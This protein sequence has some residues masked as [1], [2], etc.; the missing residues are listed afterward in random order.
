F[1]SPKSQLRVSILPI[2]RP[3]PSSGPR[4]QASAAKLS[5]GNFQIQL[6]LDASCHAVISAR[7]SQPQ[8]LPTPP[9]C[10]FDHIVGIVTR[11]EIALRSRKMRK[12]AR[13]SITLI[14]FRSLAHVGGRQR[15]AFYSRESLTP[16]CPVRGS[17]NG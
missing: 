1:N 2:R 7:P 13:H 17:F 16:L 9:F 5:K 4:L 10:H 6:R 11:S 14:V 12:L 3:Q 8:S 15:M